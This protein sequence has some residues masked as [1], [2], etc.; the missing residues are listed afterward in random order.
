MRKVFIETGTC[1]G[2]TCRM[3]SPHF[4]KVRTIE[5]FEPLYQ[6]SLASFKDYVEA[7]LGDSVDVLPRL[8][9]DY[10]FYMDADS[11]HNPE[12]PVPLLKEIEVI[13]KKPLGPI[14]CGRSEAMEKR[15][16][17][18]HLQRG[19]LFSIQTRSD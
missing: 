19:H 11:S 10:T 5:I 17:A 3:V 8:Y 4:E 16:L 7:H 18:G 14:H 6:E 15:T 9:E 13:N 1:K 2:V 12:H